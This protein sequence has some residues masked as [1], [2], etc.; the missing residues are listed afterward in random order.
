MREKLFI[1]LG[2][3][4]AIVAVYWQL[5]QCEFINYDDHEYVAEN[6]RINHGFTSS[7]VSWACQ[8]KVV[9][10]W[11][12]LTVFSHMLD[13][14]LFGVNP[15]AHHLVNLL[16]HAL[17]TLL[18]FQVLQKLTREVWPSAIVT[19]L[20]AL[21]PLHVES[22]AWISERKDVLSAFFGLLTIWTF[23]RYAQAVVQSSRFEVICCRFFFSC[24]A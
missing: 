19:A 10:N 20:F 23:A 7:S 16:F 12:P 11:H 9:S 5:G 18:L 21:H 2:L 4:L 14:Q 22:V 6:P 15:R 24:S 3:L 17:N 13:C 8:A 1:S